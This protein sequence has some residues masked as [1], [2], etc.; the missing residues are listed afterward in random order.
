MALSKLPYINSINETMKMAPSIIIVDNPSFNDS[1]VLIDLEYGFQHTDT[2]TTLCITAHKCTVCLGIPRTPVMFNPCW[3]IF[4]NS[5]IENVRTRSLEG[6]YVSCPTC[7]SLSKQSGGLVSYDRWPTLMRQVWKSMRVKCAHCKLFCSD[8]ITV[9]KHELEQCEERPIHCHEYSCD[10]TGNF[11]QVVEHML[12]CPFVLVCC[13]GCNYYTSIA[14]IDLHNCDEVK[15]RVMALP[16][17][18][19]T[20]IRTGNAGELAPGTV[21]WSIEQQLSIEEVSAADDNDKETTMD[22]LVFTSPLPR[23]PPLPHF[24]QTPSPP[25]PTTTRNGAERSNLVTSTPIAQRRGNNNNNNNNAI[26]IRYNDGRR[27][28]RSRRRIVF[29]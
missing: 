14:Y 7:R 27:I 5:C 22:V 1:S 20:R 2:M 24:P 26:D 3:H 16:A 11:K 15:S 19:R 18:S 13:T 29:E 10:F 8:P 21:F 28:L 4:C 9:A 17:S 25:T 12:E 6:R 23:T